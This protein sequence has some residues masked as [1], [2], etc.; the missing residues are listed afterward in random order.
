MTNQWRVLDLSAFSGRLSAARGAI[1]IV[2]DSGETTRVP[3]ADLAVVLIGIKV[4]FSAAVLHRLAGA[5]VSVLLCDWR[6]VPEGA[7]YAWSANSRI[8]ARQ[9][10]QAWLSLPR[11]KNAWGRIVAAKVRG[12]ASVLRT[13]RVDGEQRL[14]GMARAV[15]SGD[16]ENIEAQAARIYWSRL[17]PESERR[18]PGAGLKEGA[19][20]CL[21]YGYTILR[22][23]GLRAVLAAGLNPA[24]GIF[25]RGRSNGFAL[26][27]DLIEPFR[28]C[29]DTAVMSLGR[30]ASPEDR[31]VKAQ[32]VAAASQR[33]TCEGLTVPTVFLDFA[34]QYAR[35]CE[36]DIDRLPVP[37][38]NGADRVGNDCHG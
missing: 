16:P 25:H 3:V 17:L 38:W 10:S 7:A 28:P 18:V 31:T 20:A 30:G 6:G 13:S 37:V 32:L 8:G 33:F 11:Q 29:I 22:G 19:N 9:R 1:E 36:G 24:L 15:R 23:H 34:Q 12:Q 21:D 14:L 2:P 27:D 26:V 4:H 5:D 35:Y